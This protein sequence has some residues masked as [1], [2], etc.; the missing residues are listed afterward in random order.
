M[1]KAL[2]ITII[3]LLALSSCQKSGMQLFRGD[4]SF[5]ISGSVIFE[6]TVSDGDPIEPLSFTASL[7]NEIGQLEISALGNEKDSLLVVM[8]TMGGEVIVTHALCDG[9]EI[10]LKDFTKNTLLFTGDSITLKN[11]VLVQASGHM[12][13]DNTIILNMIY[14]GEAETSERSFTI[15][16]DN[17]RLAATRN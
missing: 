2:L 17:I 7:P 8:N 15:H 9:N 13:E 3:A 14:D 6:E 1:K 16:G 12:Y 11:E 10:V 5:K 4:Y